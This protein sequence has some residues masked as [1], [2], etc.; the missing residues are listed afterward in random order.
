L[1]PPPINPVQLAP[2]SPAKTA[3]RRALRWPS[4]GD[5]GASADLDGFPTGQ[6]QSTR[7]SAGLYATHSEPFLAAL[8]DARDRILMVDPYLL[9]EKVEHRRTFCGV[10]GN[11]IRSTGASVIRLITSA[12]QGHED[13]ARELKAIQGDRNRLSSQAYCEI[14]VRI[15]RDIRRGVPLPHD[16]FAVI[17]DE[18]WHWGANIGGTHNEVHAYSRGW[19]AS[20][21]RAVDYFDELWRSAENVR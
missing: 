10:F 2:S 18:L 19:S 5:D 4:F 21:T 13:Q 15:V 7:R 6:Q 12:K 8:K 9:A 3:L 11:T 20:M 17:D 1:K 16:R 14:D